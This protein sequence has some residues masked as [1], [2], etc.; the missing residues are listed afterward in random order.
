MALSFRDQL[1]SS[2]PQFVQALRIRHSRIIT[3]DRADYYLIDT[4]YNVIKVA[5]SFTHSS[6]DFKYIAYATFVEKYCSLFVLGRVLQWKT[7]DDLKAWMSMI[8][9][10]TPRFID[11]YY[12]SLVMSAIPQRLPQGYGIIGMFSF[13]KNNGFQTFT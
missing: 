10:Q 13:Y 11:P 12:R 9:S 6:N 5:C 7:Y 8:E 3:D 1:A 4:S 2:C